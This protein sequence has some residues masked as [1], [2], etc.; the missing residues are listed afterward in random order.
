M[1][2][3]EKHEKMLTDMLDEER[4]RYAGDMVLGMNDALVELT[5]ALAGYTLAM[6]N[7]RIVAMAGL[8]TGISATLSMTASGYLSSREET[9][10]NAAKSCVYTGLTYLITVALLIIPYLLFPAGSYFYALGTTLAVAVAIIA[11]SITI[12]R[13][14]RSVVPA[15]L[16]DD[17]A[18]SLCVRRSP[19]SSVT[20]SRT[21]W[22]RSSESCGR[23]RFTVIARSFVR[24]TEFGA[25]LTYRSW[26]GGD[27]I[28]RYKTPLYRISK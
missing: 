19:L 13:L 2:D 1:E 4:L 24:S 20:S 27:E 7:T 15:Q 9:D 28:N 5:G 3:E 23:A 22:D 8:I 6:Q 11:R 14:P 12:W 10:K 18:I 17:G 21:R 16:S 25:K 26:A